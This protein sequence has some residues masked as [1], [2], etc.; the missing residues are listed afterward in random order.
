MFRLNTA[1]SRVIGVKF[2][3]LTRRKLMSFVSFQRNIANISIPFL[4]VRSTALLD[5]HVC[6]TPVFSLA[7]TL[8]GFK[9]DICSIR[10]CSQAECISDW[11][12]EPPWFN[13]PC[14]FFFYIYNWGGNIQPVE[15]AN[16]SSVCLMSPFKKTRVSLWLLIAAVCIF[17]RRHR[18]KF[19]LITA[20]TTLNELT[21]PDN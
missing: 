21:A 8:S 6:R 14:V 11:I 2:C 10:W 16:L 18:R 9:W 7:K 20:F 1:D 3:M 15:S 19:A 4:N 5:F 12:E 17:S 13:A